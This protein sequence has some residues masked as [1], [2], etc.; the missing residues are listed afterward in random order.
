MAVAHVYY[1]IIIIMSLSRGLWR[2]RFRAQYN[3]TKYKR[4]AW[5]LFWIKRLF[6]LRWARANITRGGPSIRFF[7]FVR[8][9]PRSEPGED[10]AGGHSRGECD[11]EIESERERESTSGRENGWAIG[12]RTPVA[13][14]SSS[15]RRLQTTP[16]TERHSES[17]III[18][19]SRR[20]W[21]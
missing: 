13:S 21:F 4:N 3:K 6:F 8:S 11:V 2:E 1:V 12:G 15:V 5:L 20:K 14:I 16:P 10:F 7:F 18:R 19:G 9:D 17:K